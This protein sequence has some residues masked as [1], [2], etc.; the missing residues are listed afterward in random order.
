MMQSL[1]SIRYIGFVPCNLLPPDILLKHLSGMPVSVLSQTT[2]IEHYGDASCEAVSEY[3]N[4]SSLE[5][6]TLQFTTTDEIPTNQE[7]AFVIEDVQGKTYIIGQKEAP[8]PMVE[9]DTKIDG[10]ENV[11]EVKVVFSAKKSLIKCTF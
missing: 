9:I 7:L 10:K 5:K 3:D 8:F 6:T 4:G 2:P 1:H 11:K